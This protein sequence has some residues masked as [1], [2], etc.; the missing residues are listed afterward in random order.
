MSWRISGSQDE[1]NSPGAA[2]ARGPSAGFDPAAIKYVCTS[3][4]NQARTGFEQVAIKYGCTSV[5]SEAARGP[6]ESG[7]AGEQVAFVD[8]SQSFG[9]IAGSD[10]DP[11]AGRPS[12]AGTGLVA[13][14]DDSEPFG[15]IAGSDLDPE[16]G[17]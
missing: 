8:D 12:T 2:A 4:A 6:S 16:S 17:R 14:I 15:V 5:A 3:V 9:V 1:P 13:Y 11:D 10:L 7:S